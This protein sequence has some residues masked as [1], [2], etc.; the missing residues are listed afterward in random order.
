MGRDLWISEF[1]EQQMRVGIV[2]HKNPMATPSGIDL[3]RLRAIAGG[4]R[5]R[6][7]D[8]E[9]IA[10][11]EGEAE[12]EGGI[13]V[14][15]LAALKKP[16]YYDIVK[17]S[18]HSSIMFVANYQGPVV[19]RIV[20]VVD[21]RLPERDEPFR[22]HLLQCQRLIAERANVV[23]LNNVENKIRWRQLY[24]PAPRIA[25]VPTGCPA[26]LPTSR[27]NPYANGENAILFLGSLA[28]PR[29]VNMMNETARR[30]RDSAMV[31]LVGLNKACMYGGDRDCLLDER[32]IHHGELCEADVWDFVRHAS[33]GLALATGPLPFDN[34]VSK[35]LNYLR[36]GLPVLSEEPIVNNALVRETGFGKIFP[37]GDVE[38]LVQT[39][40]SLLEHPPNDKKEAVMRYMAAEHSWDRRVETYL[41]LFERVLSHS[42]RKDES[43][44]EEKDN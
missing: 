43:D 21:E 28:A 8:A 31:H 3:V 26:E 32:I 37:Y 27:T 11:I 44:R 30:L 12:L 40:L 35:I 23:V 13:P 18:Y 17:T 20:R 19:A 6:G 25:L 39:A 29:M 5:K 42:P 34:D 15:G 22:E 38:R 16:N 2:F 9:I 41:D 7:V 10:Q 24:G 36:G 14:R 33:I 4:L 1:K